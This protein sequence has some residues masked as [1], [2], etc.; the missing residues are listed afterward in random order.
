MSPEQAAG[1]KLDGRSDK[2]LENRTLEGHEAEVA[3]VLEAIRVYPF[4]GTCGPSCWESRLR[5]YTTALE[6][7]WLQ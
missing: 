5:L 2:L 4:R 7:W 3:M 1:R 6:D